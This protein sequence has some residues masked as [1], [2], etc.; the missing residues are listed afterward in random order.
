MKQNKNV[1][2]FSIASCI[3]VLFNRFQNVKPFVLVWAMGMVWVKNSIE[4]LLEDRIYL[5]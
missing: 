5:H 1:V 4:N 2:N 3:Y